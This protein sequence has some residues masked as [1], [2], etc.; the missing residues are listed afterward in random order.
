MSGAHQSVSHL[1]VD[2]NTDV[3]RQGWFKCRI[4]KGRHMQRC[5]KE[6]KRLQAKSGKAGRS[7]YDPRCLSLSLSLSPSAALTQT[8]AVTSSAASDCCCTRHSPP[9][10]GHRSMSNPFVPSTSFTSTPPSLAD[11][12]Y[13]T[14]LVRRQTCL[15]FSSTLVQP[16]DGPSSGSTSDSRPPIHA[17]PP[18]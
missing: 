9:A 7:S 14:N 16:L 18:P 5:A 2:A 13:D 11:A 8:R 1:R 10:L 17:I 3:G 15:C 12:N 4:R 6:R